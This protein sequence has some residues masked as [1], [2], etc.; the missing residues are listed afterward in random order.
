MNF[1]NATVS[2]ILLHLLNNV[3]LGHFFL[4]V[5]NPEYLAAYK[6]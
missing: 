2:F 6:I 1:L 5:K 4:I 3:K